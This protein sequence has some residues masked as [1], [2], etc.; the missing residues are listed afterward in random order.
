MNSALQC[1]SNVAPL[2]EY[3]MTGKF[4]DEIN[5][6]NFLGHK[7]EIVSRFAEVIHMLWNTKGFAFS[8]NAFKK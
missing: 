5:K 1:L 6:D 4:K 3:F 8:P 7:G 2:R